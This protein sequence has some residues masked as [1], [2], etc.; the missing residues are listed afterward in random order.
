MLSTQGPRMAKGDI[1]GDGL[2]DLYICGAK[3]QAGALYL[4]AKTG[5][6]TKTNEKLLE[7]DKESEDT[8]AVFFD[9]DLDGDQDLYVCSGGSGFSANATALIDR[10]YL[11][12]GQGRFTRSPQVLPSFMFES[13][14]CVK[15]G[16]YDKDG[17]PDL[18]VGVR[19][20]PFSYGYA[21]KG[22]VLQNN[23]KGLFKDV[24]ESVAPELLQAGMVTDARWLDYD[25]DGK[26]DLVVTGEYM[27][28]RLFHNEE[29]KLKEVTSEAGL[30]NSSGWWNRIE[31]ADVNGDGFMDIIGANHGLNS[32]FK[33]STEKPVEM[34]VSDFDNN[35]SIEQIITCYNGD[36]AYP[37]ALRHDLVG[38]L[39]Y[40]KKKYLKYEDYKNQTIRDVFTEEQLGEA[41]RLDATTFESS[42]FLSDG[43]GGFNQKPL[44]AEA[45]LSPMYAIVVEDMDGDGK[46]DILMGG[47][48]YES[49]PEAGIYDASQGVVLK[50]DG[51]GGF[52]PLHSRQSRLLIKGAIRDLKLIKAG[53]ET[54]LIVA[55]NN[56]KVE[57]RKMKK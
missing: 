50:G 19:V 47:N 48:F 27:P 7:R 29:G 20:K 5:G 56:E 53:K 42:V 21:C 3:D 31:T 28:V 54:L 16:D 38:V 57:I 17:D 36:S 13:S 11:N 32:R 34:W 24:T 1:N 55:K 18:F 51:K 46:Q 52:T 10:L 6:F 2:E 22:Y 26:T 15:A 33:A 45:Q 40:L 23:G 4:Q 25:R 12:D 39:P 37:M 41:L 14:S 44:P 8:D 35:G 30:Q 49:K 43:K 9:C